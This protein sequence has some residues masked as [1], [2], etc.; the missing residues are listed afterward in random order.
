MQ[1]TASGI[2]VCISIRSKR[3]KVETAIRESRKLQEVIVVIIKDF[4]YRHHICQGQAEG[5]AITAV[6]VGSCPYN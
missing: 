3:R 2:T 6:Y 1:H 5:I 4:R